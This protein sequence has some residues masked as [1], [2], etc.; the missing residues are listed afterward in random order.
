MS[1]P[2]IVVVFNNDNKF[3]DDICLV[4]KDIEGA[5]VAPP[6]NHSRV[7]NYPHFIF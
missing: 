2:K 5:S 6:N 1:A 7:F 4:N 3:A